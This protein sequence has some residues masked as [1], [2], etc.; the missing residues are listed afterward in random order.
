MDG[1]SLVF[2]VVRIT[3]EDGPAV[4]HARGP[5]SAAANAID[6][7][8]AQHL[9]ALLVPEISVVETDP[10]GGGVAAAAEGELHGARAGLRAMRVTRRIVVVGDEDL[11]ADQRVVAG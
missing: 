3:P 4:P 5:G 7:L 1:V 9:T 2:G 11:R 6:R 10:D 8:R